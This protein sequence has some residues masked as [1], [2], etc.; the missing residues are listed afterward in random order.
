MFDAQ[1]FESLVMILVISGLLISY[2]IVLGK[3][4]N[5]RVR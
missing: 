2:G 3:T 5:P 4:E 1:I